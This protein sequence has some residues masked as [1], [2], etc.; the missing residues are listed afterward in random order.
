MKTLLVVG[1]GLTGSTLARR[2]AEAGF[3]I[4]VIDERDH[5]AGNCHTRR[6]PDTG[7]MLHVHG[8][9]IFHTDDENVWS[10]V[11][12]FGEFVTYQ[13]KVKTVSR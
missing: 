6:D 8:A 3:Q 4:T 1:A 11:N 10:F 12:R 5:V 13:H 7:I 2:L 9:H